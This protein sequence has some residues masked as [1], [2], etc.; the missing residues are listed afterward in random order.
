MIEIVSQGNASTA[1]REFAALTGGLKL[2]SIVALEPSKI[3]ARNSHVLVGLARGDAKYVQGIHSSPLG[4]G[5]I[6][7]VGD[8]DFYVNGPSATV[9]GAQNVIEAACRPVR[10]FAETVIPGNENDFPARAVSSLKQYENN[11]AYA[12]RAYM[13]IN[14]QTNVKGDYI[15]KVNEQAPFGRRSEAQRIPLVNSGARTGAWKDEQ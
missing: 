9:P 1:A 10:Y 4:M 2:N 14:T 8:V 5:T 15:L 6:A 13:G 3:F 12:K 7:R 11:A